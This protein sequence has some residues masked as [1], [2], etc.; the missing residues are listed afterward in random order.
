VSFAI[1]F[2]QGG[3]SFFTW[4]NN[5][6]ANALAARGR[7]ESDPARR[8]QIYRQIQRLWYED[9]H[10]LALYHSPFVSVTRKWVRGFHQNPFGY[11]SL[12]RAWL[13]KR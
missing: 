11:W 12:T 1:D 13:S 5:A 9:Q 7:T 3:N 6:Q 2:T 4:Y 10:M 8:E